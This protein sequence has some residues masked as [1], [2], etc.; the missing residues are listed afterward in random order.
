MMNSNNIIDIYPLSPLQQGML[1]HSIYSKGSGEYIEQL[2]CR[3]IGPLNLDAFE[4]AW[5]KLIDRHSILRT[6]FVWEGLDEPVQ[7][8]HD[9]VPFRVERLDWLHLS[10]AEQQ[11]LLDQLLEQRRRDGFQITRAPLF[12]V[13][14]IRVA[15]NAHQLIWICHHLLIDGWSFPLLF[16]ELFSCYEALCR[17]Q[18]PSFR[19]VRPYRDYIA[20]LQQQDQNQ[21]AQFWQEQIRGFDT[22]SS[23]KIER[24]TNFDPGEPEYQTTTIYLPSQLTHELQAFARRHQV[25][26]NT[27]FQ[28]AWILLLNHYNGEADILFGATVSGR[29]PELPGA[30]HILG[31]F[32]N[33]L[34]VRFKVE[35]DARL[36]GWLRQLRQL[37]SEMHQYQ[38][39]LLADIQK[40]SDVPRDTPLFDTI[41]VFENYP[42]SQ[43]LAEQKRALEIQDIRAYSRTNYPITLVVAP[44]DPIRVEIAFDARRFERQAIDRV[45][46]HLERILSDIVAQPDRTLDTFSVIEPTEY[47][48]IVV[49]WNQTHSDYPA[50]RCIHE[51]ITEQ[52]ERTPE[53][54]AIRFEETEIS[55]HQLNQRS[56]QLANYL[57]KQGVTIE[58]VVAVCHERSPELI[59]SLLGVLKAGA[60]YLPL[61]PNYPKERLNLIVQDAGATILLTQ[62]HLSEKFHDLQLISI[63]MDSDWPSIEVESNA[64]LKSSALPDNLAYVIYTSGSTGRPK[65]T[66]I[67]HRGLVNHAFH[68]ARQ[69]RLGIDSRVLQLLSLSFDAAAEEIFPTL[70]SGGTLVLHRAP[71]ELPIR[72]LLNFCEKQKITLLHLPVVI[73]HQMVDEIKEKQ[74]Q[75]GASLR[76]VIIGGEAPAQTRLIAW[77]EAVN[78]R[79]ELTNAYGPTE[80]TIAA[81]LFELPNS[82]K[83]VAQLPR[84]P[85]GRPIANARIYILD[86]RL[87]PVPIGVMG[88]LYIAGIGLARGYLS[89]PAMTAEKFIPDPFSTMPGERM[90]RTGDLAYYRTDGHITFVGR[91]D[92]QI[93]LRGFRIELEEVE[94]A[95]LQHPGVA[96][97][98]VV[99]KA[100]HGMAARQDDRQLVAYFVPTDRRNGGV[101]PTELSD[102]LKARL[103]NYMVPAIFIQLEKLPITPS[104]K[105]DRRR[106]PEP[107]MELL[108]GRQ[109]YVAPRHPTEEIIANFFSQILDLPQVGIHDNFFH[110]GGHSLLAT[111]LLS[112]IRDTFQIDLEL[113]S[114][115]E[116][117]TVAEIAACVEATRLAQQGLSA[118]P[119]TSVPRDQDLPL[120]FAQLRLW[121]L[122]QLAPGQALYTIPTALRLRGKLN[123]RALEQSINELIRRHEVLRTTF[124]SRDGQPFQVIAPT[125]FLLPQKVDLTNLDAEQQEFQAQQL[126]KAEAQRP[127]DLARGPLLR[128]LLIKCSEQDHII[129]LT[130]HHIISDGWSVAVIIQEIAAL[131]QAF[132]AGQPSPLPRLPLQYA[133]FAHWQRQ[134]LQGTVLDRQLEY[135]REK[136]QGAPPLLQ[137]P[138]DRP[139]PPVQTF[140]GAT[141]DRQLPKELVAGLKKLSQQGEATLFMT[142]LAAFQTLLYRLSGQ[143]DICVG[144]PIANRNRTETEG[145]IGFFVNTL[146]LR[147]DLSGN[148]TFRKLLAQ[149]K[150]AALEAYAHQDIPFEMLVEQLQPQRDLSHSPLF[151]VMLVL[152]NAPQH[153]LELP[154]LTITPMAAE[155]GTAKFDLSLVAMEG[156]EGMQLSLEYNTDLFDA[157]TMARLL[158]HFQ[159]LLTG[160]IADPDMRLADYPLMSNEQLHRLIVEWNRTQ[161]E[162]PADQC[163]HQMFQSIVE[164]YP[165]QVAVSFGDQQLSYRELNRRANHLARKLRSFGVGPESLVGIYLDR[166][167]DL[168]TS[169]IAVL[170]AGGAFLPLDPQYPR[171]RVIFMIQ[172]SGLRVLI[173]QQN[174]L[175]RLADVNI[176]TICL[177]A[178]GEAWLTSD[179][180][181]DQNLPNLATS[182]NL[183][184][185]IYTSGSTGRPKGT[186]LPHRGLCNLAAAQQKAFG[187][188][189]HSRILQFAALSFDAA[190]WEL[191]MAL[192]TGATLCLAESEQIATGQGLI[193][194]LTD[195]KIT[196]VTLPPSMA[197]VMPD[198]PLPDLEVMITA[199]E[200]CTPDIV[201]RWSNGRKF[202]NAYGP[203]EATVCASMLQVEHD[204]AQGPP[205]G[206][207][208]QNFQLYVLDEYLNPVPIG[209]SGELFIGGVGLARCY[210]NRPDL[211]AEK[212]VPN[213]FSARPGDRL[214]RTGDLVRYL[215]DG[216]IEFLGRIDHQVKLRGFRIELGEIENVL[217]EHPSIQDATVIVREDIP[218]DSR[219]VAYFVPKPGESVEPG[220]LRRY[221]RD[222]L[223]DYMVPSYMIS[224]EQLPLTPSGKVDRRALPA[225]DRSRPD[226]ESRYQAPRNETE[227]KL[228]AICAE[229]LH[230][231][232]VGVFDNFFDLGGH[233]LLATQFISR[234][235]TALQ[236]EIPLR[237]LFE[238]PTIEK[239]AEAILTLRAT[240]QQPGQEPAP[241]IGRYSREGH[242]MKRSELDRPK[243]SS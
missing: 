5:Q 216:N 140:H 179:A 51:L 146:V 165:N 204:Y 214:Y 192:L 184:Y 45:L 104:G 230:L 70:I 90:Y 175:D 176:P 9:A 170:K 227:E 10:E 217:H 241:T 202:F 64:N 206:R 226:L 61:D 126:I 151:Q 39:S 68:L 243:V 182:D 154:D 158:D 197:R 237:T 142:L 48:K 141:L 103:P 72:E 53:Q 16:E 178:E 193:Q 98:V 102:F 195:Q 131:Y 166:S 105:I 69:Q 76:S 117:P 54:I 201:A 26:L 86:A 22:P 162:F 187:I 122:D 84:V 35:L 93:K 208:I 100:A 205:I 113:K 124:G 144:T 15:E 23:L 95:L 40:F 220:A 2:T 163:V 135:W 36:S 169:A 55:Y 114:I 88:E 91:N 134:W 60:A 189:N 231:D 92:H 80:A 94:Q 38:Y 14:L 164:Q 172:D 46:H 203:T 71:L 160:V 63:C 34:P 190:V 67:A 4:H 29:P 207:P 32:I 18:Q 167:P 13:V 101:H 239:L 111:R 229:L 20:W 57:K 152:Q 116:G 130:L 44:G 99:V 185:V 223:P 238:N 129:V 155:T 180:D 143:T 107:D 73:W 12:S 199:G 115:F 43:A 198:H 168:V 211:T 7:V 209:A 225:P 50:D 77:S 85:I 27:L 233:S 219:I 236:L 222:R 83:A 149:A 191:V 110:L 128:V 125:L 133:D 171:E 97:S 194:L 74:L 137:L 120:S 136:L 212:F 242:R 186:A 11:Q 87:R 79:I 132:S 28:G 65:G 213:P 109:P 47:Q 196:T 24:T 224:M 147:C 52:A 181:Q 1:F 159:T 139:R 33:T 150:T 19:S 42:I 66:L 188:T 62:Q 6:A 25:T 89:D 17:G 96:Q 58:S 81:T 161:A 75:L 56:N 49:D 123:I 177:D 215:A 157:S 138:T 59:I 200:K 119:M 108:F 21:A 218:G 234:I 30:E 228:T 127:F 112:R 240:A 148:P 118:P 31:P 221:L 235:R 8:V 173:S 82:P 156:N 145:L 232:K 153:A 106:L 3:F 41:L 174:L 210:L 121:F 78:G 37:Q 183:A